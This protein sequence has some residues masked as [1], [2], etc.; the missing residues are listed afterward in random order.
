MHVSAHLDIDLIA[1]DQADDVTCLV[2]MQAPVPALTTA[3]PGQTLVVVLDRSGSMSGPPLEGAKD[4]IAGLV[5]RLAPQDCFGLVVFDDQTEVVVPVAPMADHLPQELAAHIASVRS[6]SST[7][8]SAGYLLGLR[9]AKRS[10]ALT[11]QSGATLLLV[12][13]GQANAGIVDPIQMHDLAMSAS[14][15]DGITTSTLGLGLGYDEVLLE[16]ITRGGNG[17]HRFAP[18]VDAAKRE[19]ED[20]VTGLLDKSVVAAVLRVRPQLGLVDAVVV[21]GNLPQRV[22]GKELVVSLGDLFAGEERRTLLRLHVPA[23][24]SLGTATVAD[25]VLEYTTLPDLQEHV[26]TLPVSVN[27]VPG[28]EARLRV[29]NP[30]VQVEDLLADVDEQ[31]RDIAT[32]LRTG[33]STSARRTLGSAITDVNAKRAE[34]KEAGPTALTARLDEA[35]AELLGL[36]DDVLHQPAEY[37]SKSAMS[38]YAATSRGRRTGPVPTVTPPK[39]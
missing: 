37:S 9:E 34:L 7:D 13:D 10:L 39:S 8:L 23:L 20:V 16:A 24:H 32:S 22:E 3:R 19:I 26:V 15:T 17:S 6:G 30:L 35:A 4:A 36:A 31:K 33:D 14:R 2:Q 11:G 5:R 12:S 38:S 21:R 25:L 28:D 18:D 1:L 29:P 27:V